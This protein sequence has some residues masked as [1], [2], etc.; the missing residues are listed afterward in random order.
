MNKNYEEFRRECTKAI[1]VLGINNRA[2]EMRMLKTKKGTISGYY[3]DNEKLL[4]DIFRFDGVNNN[5]FT[6]KSF[7]KDLL[8]R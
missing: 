8:V 4:I 6:L 3:N 2:V 7:E 1:E 5:F